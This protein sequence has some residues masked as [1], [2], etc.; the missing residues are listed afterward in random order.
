MAK[1]KQLYIEQPHVCAFIYAKNDKRSSYT[2]FFH[3]IHRTIKFNRKEFLLAHA[4]PGPHSYITCVT[5]KRK[6]LNKEVV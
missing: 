1:Q 6:E 5:Q 3:N 4:L 2:G